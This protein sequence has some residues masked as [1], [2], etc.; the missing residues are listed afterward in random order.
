MRSLP[1][2]LRVVLLVLSVSGL[3]G[4]PKSAGTPDAGN[5]CGNGRLDPGEECDGD[6]PGLTCVDR[7]YHY[8]TLACTPSCSFDESG[9]VMDPCWSYPC[10]PYGTSVG[11]VVEDLSF[12]PG[13]DV[14]RSFVP[15]GETG[16]RLGSL[17]QRNARHGGDLKAL[18]VF[19]STGWC[20]YCRQEAPKLEALYQ[21]V[22][23]S[24]ALVVGLVAEDNRG[25]PATGDFANKYGVQYGWTFPAVAGTLSQNYWIQDDDAGSV[26]MHLFI[27]LSNM[28]IFGRFTGV[29]DMKIIRMALQQIAQGPRWGQ[30]GEREIDFNCAADGGT[31]EHEPNGSTLGTPENGTTLPFN[32]TGAVCP[33]TVADGMEVDEDAVELGTLSAGTLLEITM[34][35]GTGSDVY[36]FFYPLRVV[37]ARQR[38]MGRMSPAFM[39]TGQVRRQFVVDK[40][41]HYQLVATDGR[42]ISGMYYGAD[43]TPPDESSCCVGGP[44]FTYGLQIARGTLAATEPALTAGQARRDSLAEESVKVYPFQASAGVQYTIELKAADSATMDPFLLL[45]SPETSSVLAINDDADSANGIYNSKI[46]W[47]SSSAQTVWI[48]ADYFSAFF[49]GAAPQYDVVV[50]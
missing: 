34:Q 13:N 1:G 11:S 43:A 30:N 37:S 3:G 2:L 5:P 44:S 23:D 39:H 38:E 42:L 26:P 18:M 16:F 28:R 4:C 48:I 46:V 33:P 25:N 40:A 15:E 50:N 17:F 45:Y 9:C 21:E 36:P 49:K 32:M 41:G 7:G 14:S 10:A 19:V 27:D 12:T 22:K 35:S 24:G 47:D 20:P 29:G 8:G 6:L 31:T